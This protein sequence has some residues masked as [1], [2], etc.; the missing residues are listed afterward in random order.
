MSR[1]KVGVPRRKSSTGVAVPQV[2]GDSG[3]RVEVVRKA[4]TGAL[5]ASR[6]AGLRRLLLRYIFRG[7][8]GASAINFCK[9]PVPCAQDTGSTTIGER[10]PVGAAA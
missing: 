5:R 4:W 3:G 9:S 6:S 2:E 10:R 8:V 7:A 1:M